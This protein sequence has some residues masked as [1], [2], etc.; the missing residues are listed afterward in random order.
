MR[1]LKGVL[2]GNG[3]DL[4]SSALGSNTDMLE[5]VKVAADLL[6]EQLNDTFFEAGA[7]TLE[8]E[9]KKEQKKK[10]EETKQIIQA[11]AIQDSRTAADQGFSSPEAMAKAQAQQ[12]SLDALNPNNT[13]RNSIP[14]IEYEIQRQKHGTMGTL[15]HSAGGETNS[16]FKLAMDGV[17]YKEPGATAPII[18]FDKLEERVNTLK[19]LVKENFLVPTQQIF[20]F[21]RTQQAIP[22]GPKCQK[23]WKKRIS[24][25]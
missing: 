20:I 9:S 1:D 24:R 12:A 18:N 21:Q 23:G 4:L 16:A 2:T 7:A 3:F 22:S 8:N 17:T 19:N 14:A 6:R 10:E 11:Q 15:S 5:E 13:N 25:H